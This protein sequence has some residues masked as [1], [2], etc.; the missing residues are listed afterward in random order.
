[1]MF[2][3]TTTQQDAL[4]LYEG[5]YERYAEGVSTFTEKTAGNNFA[6][7][8]ANKDGM[9]I[10]VGYVDSTVLFVEVAEQYKDEVKRL[11]DALGY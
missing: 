10:Y 11:I 1:M 8:K 5:N 3:T 9:F 7:Y 4:E 2:E 6:T